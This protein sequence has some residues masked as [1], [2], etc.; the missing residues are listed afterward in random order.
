MALTTASLLDPGSL[1]GENDKRRQNNLAIEQEKTERERI[2]NDT[3]LQK[4]R[5]KSESEVARLEFYSSNPQLTD[6]NREEP[7]LLT[8]STRKNKSKKKGKN[9]RKTQKK[10]SRSNGSS[11][12]SSSSESGGSNASKK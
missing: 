7:L 10:K 5:I 1:T 3:E 9:K 2:K 4:E 12:S 6:I 11:S 8:N